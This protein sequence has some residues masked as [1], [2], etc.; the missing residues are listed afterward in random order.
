MV[1]DSSTIN[2][3]TSID[4]IR[5]AVPPGTSRRAIGAATS[6]TNCE[7]TGRRR[8]DRCRGD[9]DQ[10]ETERRPLDG[11]AE[12]GGGVVAE[13]Q[14]PEQAVEQ[15][16]RRQ[17]DGH[18]DRERDE[19]RPD[20]AVQRA[21][22]PAQRE[23]RVADVGSRQQ[24]RDH[25][26][27]H[28]ADADADENQPIPGETVLARQQ[29]DAAA[30]ASAPINAVT[31]TVSPPQFITRMANTAAA[32]APAEIPIRSGLASGFRAICCSSAPESPN[33]RPTS[34]P[35][36]ARGSR[37]SRTVNSALGSPSPEQCTERRRWARAVRLPRRCAARTRRRPTRPAR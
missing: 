4:G 32:D 1:S 18:R 24:V 11:D 37:S 27:G 10:Q 29:V 35:V 21:D 17:H 3:P 14:R 15:V 5:A 13:L 12:A 6:A 26:V 19:L 30:A 23:L 8:G 7:R 20:P 9:R 22:Q 2:D 16:R 34:T 25:G 31:D 33:A 28:R 36:S